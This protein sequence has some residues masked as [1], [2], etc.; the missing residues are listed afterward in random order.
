MLLNMGKCIQCNRVVASDGTRSLC[1]VC[2]EQYDLDAGLI[3]DAIHLHRLGTPEAIANF[4]HLSPERVTEILEGGSIYNNESEELC[5]NCKKKPSLNHSDY[6]LGCQLAIYKSLGDNMTLAANTAPKAPDPFKTS[7]LTALRNSLNDK[8]K[9]A[10]F[11]R[12][13]PSTT[14]IKGTGGK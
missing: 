14:S 11:N 8:R 5:E 12:F 3:E 10:G 2:F 6:C 4:T 13:N 9:R 7:P 1:D